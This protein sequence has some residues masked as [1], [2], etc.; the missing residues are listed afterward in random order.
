[1]SNWHT[2]RHL[3]TFEPI[4]QRHR[5]TFFYIQANILEYSIQYFNW[6]LSFGNHNFQGP[7]DLTSN[8]IFFWWK[9]LNVYIC[10][11]NFA[12]SAF[13]LL[14]WMCLVLKNGTK[15]THVYIDKK[16]NLAFRK[17]VSNLTRTAIQTTLVFN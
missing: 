17:K 10:L 1:M 6:K 9:R 5:I 15:S 4:L 12:I 11:K 7:A 14:I 16:T 8:K 2:N 13:F 3:S